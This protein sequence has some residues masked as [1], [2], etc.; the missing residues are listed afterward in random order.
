M[1]MTLIIKDKFPSQNPPSIFCERTR[2]EIVVVV[3]KTI[4]LYQYI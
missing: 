1:I 2:G 3:D 4:Y